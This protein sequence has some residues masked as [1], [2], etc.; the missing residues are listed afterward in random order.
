MFDTIVFSYLVTNP[1]VGKKIETEVIS[2]SVFI[3]KFSLGT[4]DL[5]YRQFVKDGK[6]TFHV[7]IKGDI[8]R[9]YDA[10]GLI[11]YLSDMSEYEIKNRLFKPEVDQDIQPE[12]IGY[13]DQPVAT[14]WDEDIE[15][16]NICESKSIES[17]TPVDGVCKRCVD[18]ISNSL[19]DEFKTFMQENDPD[20]N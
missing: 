13:N 10:V 5:A 11:K 19:R 6:V 16:C 8:T 18:N 17:D 7:Y 14:Y 2:T 9:D 1:V 15:V 4:L 20:S 3:V 12:T